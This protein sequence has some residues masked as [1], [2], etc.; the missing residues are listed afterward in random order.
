MRVVAPLRL[1]LPVGLKAP[2]SRLDSTQ[3]LMNNHAHEPYWFTEFFKSSGF[4]FIEEAVMPQKDAP[5][6]IAEAGG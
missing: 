4:A 3:Q 1:Q 5:F 6:P 2:G